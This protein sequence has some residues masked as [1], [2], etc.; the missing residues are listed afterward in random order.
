ML[1]AASRECSLEHAARCW[2]SICAGYV[3]Y[4]CVAHREQCVTRYL[5]LNKDL[6]RII[7]ET[8][9]ITESII[10]G[11]GDSRCVVNRYSPKIQ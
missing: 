6:E 1:T 4:L 3:N 7:S 10:R 8:V 2:N 9:K 11:T 5:E